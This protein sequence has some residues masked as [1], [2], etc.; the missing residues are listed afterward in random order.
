MITHL[1]T[2]KN[3]TDLNLSFLAIV[4]IANHYYDLIQIFLILSSLI[5]ATEVDIIITS[6]VRKLLQKLSI[7]EKLNKLWD[8]NNNRLMKLII[9]I[10]MQVKWKEK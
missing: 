10:Q 3:N 6:V 7:Q 9:N 5:T 8:E 1:S 2:Q 4:K